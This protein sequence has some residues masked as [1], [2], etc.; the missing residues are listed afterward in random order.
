VTWASCFIGKT[1][2]HICNKL[3]RRVEI[4]KIKFCACADVAVWQCTA[5]AN[6]FCKSIGFGAA[7]N[8]LGGGYIPPMAD[9]EMAS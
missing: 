3:K 6:G 4:V 2:F 5:C 8:F 1:S 9:E 7:A